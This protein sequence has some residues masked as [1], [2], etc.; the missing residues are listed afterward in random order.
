MTYT[1]EADI[2]TAI[3]QGDDMALSV[4]YKE[5]FRSIQHF[6]L[7]NTGSEHDAKD[8]YQEAIII[9]YEKVTKGGL[10]LTCKISTFLYSISRRLWLRK[11]AAKSNYTGKIEDFESFIPIPEEMNDFRESQFQAMNYSLIQLGEP[12]RTIIEDYYMHNLNMVQISEKFGYTNAE[13]AKNQKYKCL[14]RLK[15]MFFNIYKEQD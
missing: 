4:L 5:H 15:K 12:C 3:K 10:E 8:I 11:L 7:N 1:S 6:V 13:N 2:L 9:L 14:N